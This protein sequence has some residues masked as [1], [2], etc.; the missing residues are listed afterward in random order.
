MY[1]C[2]NQNGCESAQDLMSIKIGYATEKGA[3]LLTKE[4]YE[5]DFAP[6]R[7]WIK[8]ELVFRA[9]SSTKIIV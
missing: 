6:K 2:D 3:N 9:R 4:Y 7:V 5:K 8:R 1:V